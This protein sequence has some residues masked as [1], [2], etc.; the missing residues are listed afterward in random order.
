MTPIQKVDQLVEDFY[1]FV[2]NPEGN[3]DEMLDDAIDCCDKVAD[4]IIKETNEL[5]RLRFW[6]QVK[7][8][9]WQRRK[10]K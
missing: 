10:K 7:D 6:K 2:F 1:N 8:E 5:D 3:Q 4:E 9:L